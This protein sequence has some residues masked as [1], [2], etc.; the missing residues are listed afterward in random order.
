MPLMPVSPLYEGLSARGVSDVLAWLLQD[1]TAPLT[2]LLEG[3][4]G[5]PPGSLAFRAAPQDDGRLVGERELTD[6]ESARIGVGFL[7]PCCY[8]EG[9][10][11]WPGL[12]AVQSLLVWLPDRLPGS[13]HALLERGTV[14]LGT[15][16]GPR[17]LSRAD[18]L[19]LAVAGPAVDCSAVL[20]YC[21]RPFGIAAEQITPA[22]L[23]AVAG[24]GG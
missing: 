22:Y 24:S 3:M 23:H 19:A 18:R 8:R 17:H 1:R 13:T 14:P 9:T 7:E 15:L 21:G 11:S 16:L 12:D 20:C 6:E 10:L 4:A 5:R 2:P